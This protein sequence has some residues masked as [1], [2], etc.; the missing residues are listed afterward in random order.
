MNKYFI[1]ADELLL[2]SLKLGTSIIQAQFNP[3]FIIGVWRGGTPTAIAVQELLALAGINCEHCAIKTSSY[4]GIG[5]Q[6]C[7]IQVSG[8]S[9]LVPKLSKKDKLLIIDDVFDS[10]R[11]IEAIVNELKLRCA[12]E[13]P[14]HIKVAC[15]W[16]KPQSNQTRRKP[17]FYMHETDDWLVFPHELIGLSLDEIS[18]G[19]GEQIAK[20]CAP[21]LNNNPAQQ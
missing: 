16:Y 5:Q 13:L 20:L 10:G 1:S 2:D 12:E 8:L 3:D 19:K 6:R 15:P 21:L 11:S 4:T 18:K 17:D 9:E 7:T 14:E